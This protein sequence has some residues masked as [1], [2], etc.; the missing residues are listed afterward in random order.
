MP[1]TKLLRIYDAHKICPKFEPT[2]FGKLFN[3]ERDP[4]VPKDLTDN[5]KKK[6]Y[7]KM[8]DKIIKKLWH[9]N[10]KCFIDE[11]SIL[12]TANPEGNFY[13]TFKLLAKKGNNESRIS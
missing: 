7:F 1:K 11:F 13:E 12:Q 2:F 5:C 9:T 3:I 8:Q 4:D 6:E 10:R